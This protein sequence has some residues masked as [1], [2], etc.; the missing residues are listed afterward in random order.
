MP[1]LHAS[2]P[3]YTCCT[4]RT[5][6]TC[7]VHACHHTHSKILLALFLPIAAL[8]EI[9]VVEQADPSDPSICLPET[10]VTHG[11]ERSSVQTKSKGVV[12]RKQQCV[13]FLKDVNDCDGVGLDLRAPNSRWT[14]V[15]SDWPCRSWQTVTVVIN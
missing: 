8:S 11:G 15:G 14:H 10:Y 12:R 7:A 4:R 5:C 13:L 2:R 3:S 6:T 1:A 9:W